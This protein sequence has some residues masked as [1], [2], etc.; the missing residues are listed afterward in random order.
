MSRHV[1]HVEVVHTPLGAMYYQLGKDLSDLQTVIGTGGVLIHH[2]NAK[3]ILKEA[4]EKSDRKLE[5]RPSNPTVLIDQD[6]L[7]SAMGLLSQKHPDLA[8]KLMKRHLV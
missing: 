1:G 5:L 7:L 4:T 2:P 6:Y 3:E 8:L